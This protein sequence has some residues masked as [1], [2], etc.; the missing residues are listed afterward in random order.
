M[1]LELHWG[2]GSELLLG[3]GQDSVLSEQVHH[4]HADSPALLQGPRAAPTQQH[5]RPRAHL[6]Q[7][8]TKPESGSGAWVARRYQGQRGGWF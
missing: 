3:P 2:R 5:S 7:G 8:R 1:P 6:R 4:R